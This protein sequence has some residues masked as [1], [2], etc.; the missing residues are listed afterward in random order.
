M[1]LLRWETLIKPE[2]NGGANLKI[3]RET[4][5]AF[6]AK[7]A[8]RTMHCKGQTWRKVVKSK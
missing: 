5:W 3:D 2:E 7:L 4:N 1:H 8:W 6:L